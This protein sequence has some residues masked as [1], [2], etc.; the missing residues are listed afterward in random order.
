MLGVVLLMGAG[1]GA[2]Y[3]I[4]RKKGVPSGIP[5]DAF[6]P[7]ARLVDLRDGKVF[8]IEKPDVRIGR[9]PDNDLV[10]SEVTVSGYH[11]EIHLRGGRFFLRDLQSANATKL[12]ERM[13]SG[14]VPLK[15]GDILRFDVFGF[16]FVE[17]AEEDRTIV[18][19]LKLGKS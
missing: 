1:A 3:F 11:A 16:T 5:A 9:K 19:P 13:V 8:A 15:N 6:P 14:E 18:R 12:N 4:R 7:A 10:I 17:E 2:F